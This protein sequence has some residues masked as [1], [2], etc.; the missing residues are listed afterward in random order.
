MKRSSSALAQITGLYVYPIISC[1]GIS[2]QSSA[3][4]SEALM[5]DRRFIFINEKNEFQTI[6]QNARMTLI[7]PSLTAP[8]DPESC[9]LVVHLE[10]KE[11][12]GL[13]VPAI[14]KKGQ[15]TALG[16]TTEIVDI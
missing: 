14:P 6:R 11:F 13:R 5:Y 7:R 16:A 8:Q 3:F 2:L 1:R 12:P 10:G 15:L 4:M 9:E